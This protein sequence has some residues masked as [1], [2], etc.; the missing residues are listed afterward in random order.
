MQLLVN[1]VLKK[2]IYKY[3]FRTIQFC[4]C[5]KMRRSELLKTG[6]NG[7]RNIMNWKRNEKLERLVVNPG[8]YRLGKPREMIFGNL[9]DLVSKIRKSCT[10]RTC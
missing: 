2:K 10:K 9:E 1:L 3:K 8:E 5:R 7:L 6:S 4:D